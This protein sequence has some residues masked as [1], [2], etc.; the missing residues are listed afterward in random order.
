M[1]A[2]GYLPLIASAMMA[3]PMA[4]AAEAGKFYLSPFVGVESFESGVG[5]DQSVGYG[6]SGLQMFTDNLGAELSYMKSTADVHQ[7]TESVDI[8]QLFLRGIYSFGKMGYQERYEPYVSLG[9]GNV[10]FDPSN[11]KTDSETEIGAGLGVR[12]HFSDKVSAAL[13]AEQRYGTTDYYQATVYTLAVSYAFGGEKPAAAPAA[14]PVAAAPAAPLDSDGD[15]VYDDKD[16]CPNTPAGREVDEKGCEYHLKKAEEMKLDILF[17]TNK[18]VIKPQYQGEVERAAK[19]LKRYADV[20]AV[21]EGH[22]DSDGS[23][24]YN[25]KLSQSRADAVKASLITQ[26]GIA[27]SR[28]TATGYGESRPVASNATK[29]GKAQNRRVVAVFKAEVEIDPNKK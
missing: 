17:D 16:Q 13:G 28:L 20:Q 18:S 9:V 26:Y 1:K 19:F 14:A 6:L 25:Q 12:F 4:A 29:D 11:G 24:A 15:G 23:D 8:D 7:S 10:S 27:A 3:L 2:R 21:I 22:T 5:L